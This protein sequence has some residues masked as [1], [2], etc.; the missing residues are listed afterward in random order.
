M[1]LLVVY[2]GFPHLLHPGCPVTYFKWQV[3]V[4][5]QW[6][7]AWEIF[8]PVSNPGIPAVP[9]TPCG[10]LGLQTT[11]LLLL[12]TSILPRKIPFQVISPPVWQGN[13]ALYRVNPPGVQASRIEQTTCVL[14]GRRSSLHSRSYGGRWG[15]VHW[16]CACGQS[17]VPTAPGPPAW[18]CF[19]FVERAV[20]FPLGAG[21]PLPTYEGTSY[22][23]S[24]LPVFPV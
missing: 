10:Q 13:P 22:T 24:G 2:P 19:P 8:H 7:S 14:A 21:L 11:L 20:S 6:S 15:R 9:F 1:S 4:L 17:Q 23:H 3:L 12:T 16:I 18:T 5:P